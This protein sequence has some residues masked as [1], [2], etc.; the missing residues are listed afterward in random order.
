M[1]KFYFKSLLCIS[2]LAITSACSQDVADQPVSPGNVT[3]KKTHKVSLEDAL[4]RSKVFQDGLNGGL[5]TRAM[6]SSDIESVEYLGSGIKTRGCDAD[7]LFY[8]VNYK[9][10]QG[11]ML[12]S[13]D[14]RMLPVYAMSDEGRLNLND[15]TFN[16]GLRAFFNLAKA[17]A[18][19]I[20]NPLDTTKFGGNIVIDPFDYTYDRTVRPKFSKNLRSIGQESPFNKY[21]YTKTGEKALA[22]CGPVAVAS[23]LAYYGVPICIRGRDI[24]WASINEDVRNDDFFYL[25]WEIGQKDYLDATYGTNGTSCYLLDIWTSFP[26]LGLKCSDMVTFNDINAAKALED[27]PIFVYG[28]SP[29]DGHFWIMDGYIRYG[30]LHHLSTVPEPGRSYPYFFFH[31]CWGWGGNANGYYYYNSNNAINGTADRFDPEDDSS[32]YNANFYNMYMICH[33]IRKVTI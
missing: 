15:T 31:C 9:D 3:S 8:L 14:E 4:E 25:I 1:C 27:N 10:E 16:E 12:L 22:G 5:G 26:K 20:T 11:F 33:F 17:D 24:D 2:I 13:A 7:T 29:G 28:E 32:S 18:L 30:A 21:C 19:S 6:Q 23:Q